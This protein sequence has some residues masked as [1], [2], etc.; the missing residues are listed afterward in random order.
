ML[1]TGGV[2][3]VLSLAWLWMIEGVRPDRWDMIG[4]TVCLVGASMILLMPRQ[5]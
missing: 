3:I 4:A 2:Y 1:P 5:I